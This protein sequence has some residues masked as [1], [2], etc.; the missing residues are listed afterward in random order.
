MW[1]E[2]CKIKTSAECSLHNKAIISLKWG[3]SHYQFED[4]HEWSYLILVNWR[5]VS[6]T[7]CFLALVS[8][9]AS[10]YGSLSFKGQ[11]HHSL[12]IFL[13][14]VI[15]GTQIFPELSEGL[16]LC[17]GRFRL[18][19]R[20]NFFFKRVVMCWNRLPREVVESPSLEVWRT[21]AGWWCDLRG[22][23]QP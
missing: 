19:I 2:F 10:V 3:L 20:R 11:S 18:D 7:C 15:L 17:Q 12:A 1:N 8:R 16:R 23:F 21:C 4:W 6:G 13:G 22:L 14:H 5:G 9:K